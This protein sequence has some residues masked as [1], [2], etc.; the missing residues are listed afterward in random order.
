METGDG[1]HDRA[2]VMADLRTVRIGDRDITVAKLS[3]FKA[4]RASEMLADLLEV[5][6]G[7]IEEANGYAK[8]MQEKNTVRVTRAM[9]RNPA[10]RDEYGIVEEDFGADGEDV[11]ELP[12]AAPPTQEV[13]GRRRAEADA[14]RAASAR[15]AR[16]ARAGPELRAG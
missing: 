10:F 9:V 11:L 8:E 4:L 12:G 5:V 2:H 15:R 1:Q 3:T 6:P 14:D 16:R 7:L 13:D